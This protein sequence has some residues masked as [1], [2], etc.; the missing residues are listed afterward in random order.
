MEIENLQQQIIEG[1]KARKQIETANESER[2]L[3]QE[4][5]KGGYMARSHLVWI[6]K[7]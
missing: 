3:L 6:Q 2:E 7:R 4:Q 1:Y 5:I